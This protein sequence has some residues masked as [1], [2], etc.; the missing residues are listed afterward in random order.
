MGPGWGVIYETHY[1]LHIIQSQL[2]KYT[3]IFLKFQ[4]MT[5]NMHIFLIL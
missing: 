1:I 3:K 4:N 2:G 5:S